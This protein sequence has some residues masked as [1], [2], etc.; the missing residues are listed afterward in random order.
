MHKYAQ[1]IAKHKGLWVTVVLPLTFYK[2]EPY[3]VLNA[4]EENQ[5]PQ[6]YKCDPS[7]LSE[8]QLGAGINHLYEGYPELPDEFPL[9]P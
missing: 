6:M 7:K 9:V 3:L 1:C 8:I 4:H 2:Q 5:A